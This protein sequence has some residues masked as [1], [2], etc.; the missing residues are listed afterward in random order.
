[1]V[2]KLLQENIEMD[3]DRKQSVLDAPMPTTAKAM[4]KFL[5]VAVFFNEFIPSYSDVTGK[6]YEMIN[7]KFSWDKTTW[8]YD[9]EAEFE[10]AKVALANCT[11][12]HFPN[13]EWDWILRTDASQTGS[14]VECS[15]KWIQLIPVIRKYQP[16][17]LQVEEILRCGYEVDTHK[18]EAFAIYY[19]VKAFSYYLYAKKFIIETDHRNLLWMGSSEALNCYQ[20][21]NI[22]TV[23]QFFAQ[24]H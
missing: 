17:R 7:P 10:K 18:Q 19:C 15:C 2:I 14:C 4:Q 3:V 24:R 16:H 23:F 1:L 22:F 8:K 11:A 21:E 12:K 9:Y 13:Y 6:L 5:G 20:M